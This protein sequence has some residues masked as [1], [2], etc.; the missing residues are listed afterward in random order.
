M[1]YPS[2]LRGLSVY[3][4]SQ[5]PAGPPG[6]DQD[7]P[8]AFFWRI[9]D[10]I[11][12]G[13]RQDGLVQR[14][15]NAQLLLPAGSK[16]PADL[17]DLWCRLL[18]A[19]DGL[20]VSARLLADS[21]LGICTA[22]LAQAWARIGGA[23]QQRQGPSQYEYTLSFDELANDAERPGLL[24]KLGITLVF[25]GS[26]AAAGALRL[27]SGNG[28]SSQ[29]AGLLLL[30]SL[31]KRANLSRIPSLQEIRSPFMGVVAEHL[32]QDRA[33]DISVCEELGLQGDAVWTWSR[34][35]SSPAQSAPAVAVFVHGGG[36]VSGDYY[37]YRS[38]C[39]HLSRQTGLP[40]LFP[41]YRLAPEHTI[42]D[43]IDDVVEALQFVLGRGQR[44]VLLGDS[45]GGGLALL[46]MQRMVAEAPQKQQQ[47]LPARGEGRDPEEPLMPSAVVL[48]SPLADLSRSQPTHLANAD[49]DMVFAPEL[50]EA[51]YNMALQSCDAS[52]E[53]PS[54]SPL[55]G[56]FEGL[57][58]MLINVSSNEL[59]FGDSTGVAAA[60]R[61]AGCR[62]DLDVVD[63]LF[64]VYPLMY[65]YVPEAIRAMARIKRWIACRLSSPSLPVPPAV[66]PECLTP[67][68][69]SD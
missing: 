49:V 28:L 29:A 67:S 3:T 55:N 54:V 60:A 53:C 45:A 27:Q 58:P 11:K 59:L 48:M 4:G 42:A 24:R 31:S 19:A 62:V 37:G 51:G 69:G 15:C 39:Y 20:W 9:D 23:L 12:P 57:P 6:S 16:R 63:N 22:K 18:A 35:L 56:S 30:L 40:V 21:L 34:R 38:Y 47:G 44:V 66:P 8:R 64:H 46:A 10:E 33:S 50:M 68:G 1:A 5:R 13:C 32:F 61:G 14:A 36:F 65:P 7:R 52:P 41:Q 43:A 26:L 17:Q 2:A 25:F